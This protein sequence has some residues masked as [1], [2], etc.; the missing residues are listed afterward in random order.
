MANVIEKKNRRILVIDD[1]EAIHEDFR[2]ILSR[3]ITNAPLDAARNAVFGADAKTTAESF[4]VDCAFDGRDG[5]LKVIESQKSSTPYATAFVD[6]RME[7]DWDGIE[8]IEQ[9]WRVQPDL[10]M[11]LC[12]AYSDYSWTEIIDRL[13][14]TERLL[15]LKKPFDNMEVRQMACALTEKWEL[16]NQLE[17]L[18]QER[19]TQI[20]ETRDVAMF[21]IASLAE[22]RDPETGE[23]L[24]RIRSYCHILAEELRTDSAYSEWIDDKF[25]GDLYRSSPLHDI[26]K[27]GIPD[28]ILLKPGSLT[29]DEFEIMKQHSLIGSE[30][31]GKTI[32]TVTNA[33]FLEMAA[34][35]AKYHHERFD[36]TGYP[37]GLKGKEIPLAARIVAVADVYDALTSSRVYK[38]AFRPEIAYMMVCQEAG[39]HFDSVVVDAFI[40][41][42]D[43]FLQVRGTTKAEQTA[44]SLV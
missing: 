34:D 40:R 8:T 23:H 24:E 36:G 30:A 14:P 17:T 11:V 7:S 37:E 21:V 3:G 12:T 27:V 33:G 9:L 5:L 18:V 20:A 16:L 19:T 15:I 39:K 32:R 10:Q 1:K 2:Q 22:S 44:T 25:I 43:D 42:H 29:D 31:L 41:K 6:L 13:G 35:I 26:G 28:C 38:P 4:E